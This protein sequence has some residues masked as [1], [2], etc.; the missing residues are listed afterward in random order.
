MKVGLIMI[1]NYFMIESN[2]EDVPSTIEI[3]TYNV[4][5]ILENVRESNLCSTID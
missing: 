2:T 5:R 4:K 3:T 1:I